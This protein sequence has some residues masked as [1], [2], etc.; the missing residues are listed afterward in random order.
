LLEQYQRRLAATERYAEDTERAMERMR[1][2]FELVLSSIDAGRQELLRIHRAGLIE[3]EVLH[4]LERD[5]D[6]EELG[7]ILQL[8][9]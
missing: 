3:D 4:N 7:M 5:L 8:S 9:D 1:A 6:V 2:H